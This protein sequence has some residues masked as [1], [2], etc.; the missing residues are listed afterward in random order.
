[1][2]RRFFM[3]LSL[4][5]LAA[6]VANA[7][8]PA[9]GSDKKGV[10]FMNRI[11]PSISDVYI[12]N[13][14][15]TGERKLLADSAYEYNASPS[16]DGRY[17]VFTSERMGDGQSDLFRARIDGTGIEP[18]V[19][20]ST[21][22]DA[23]VLSP[24]GSKLAFVSTRNGTRANVWVMDMAT[25]ALTQLTGTTAVR[26][27][28]GLPDC[29]FRPHWSPDGQWLAFSSDRNTRWYGHDGGQGWEHTQELALYMIRPDGTG[30]RKIAQKPG[31]C[32]GSPRFSPDGKRIC[33]Y[34]MTTEATWGARRPNYVGKS[35]SQIVSLDLSTMEWTYHTTGPDL[36]LSPQFVTNEEIGYL[37]KYGPNEGLHYTAG[38]PDGKSVI[39]EKTS[40]M[41]IRPFNKPLYSWDKDWEYRHLD[42]FPQIGRDG[43]LVYTEKQL[44]NSSIYIMRPDGSQ[45]TKVFESSGHGLD[46]AKVKMGLAGAFQPAW[47]ADGKWIVFGLGYWFT[48]RSHET[49]AIWR[50]K[51]DGTGFEQLT[52]GTLHSGFPSVDPRNSD[53]IVFRVW[54]EKE[55]GLRLMDIK[56]RK[57]TVLTEGLDNLP[58]WSPD[59]KEIVF[60]RKRAD[61]N[62]DVYTINP[63]TKELR[64]ITTHDSSDGHAVWSWDNRIMWSGSEHGFRDEAALYEMTFQQYG[65]IYVS[66]RDGSNKR[67]VTDSKW[68]DSMPIYVPK[69]LFPGAPNKK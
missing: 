48:E 45:K 13:L 40:F 8:A 35:P 22:D 25:R 43:W 63:E 36:K 49:A 47:S 44:G 59:G 29:Y 38:R 31:Y 26:G 51:R 50:V 3:G 27:E 5:S 15:G 14:D 57:I 4:G 61:T 46:L 18:L 67:L 30:F 1:M 64:R 58:G 17:V 6:G 41:P 56:T 33:F 69:N 20:D 52:D 12:A 54:S 11:A 7:A 53:R 23:G 34:E 55:K 37:V 10:F 65:Q 68:E 19:T 42:V 32:L 2:D 62:F 60:T 16:A 21:M 28:E 24:D 9:V 39:Y 66:D